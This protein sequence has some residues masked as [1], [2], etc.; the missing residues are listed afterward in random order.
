[1]YSPNSVCPISLLR[2]LFFWLKTFCIYL[3]TI[4]GSIWAT[5][6]TKPDSNQ[7]RK[8][9]RSARPATI[10]AKI[11]AVAA[12]G[13]RSIA[14]WSLR[15]QHL[16]Q[17]HDSPTIRIPIKRKKHV[18]SP[19]RYPDGDNNERWLIIAKLYSCNNPDPKNVNIAETRWLN[20]P[21][22]RAGIYIVR[23]SNAFTGR[24][25]RTPHVSL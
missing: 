23:F 18:T 25:H 24:F 21:D 4:C 11:D 13:R 9:Y 15:G 2:V 6:S 16:F 19:S 10:N 1:M 7:P 22:F 14:V 5:A 17:I 12:E 20:N 3:H 8:K